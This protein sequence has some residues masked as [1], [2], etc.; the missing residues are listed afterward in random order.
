MRNRAFPFARRN[1]VV[2]LPVVDRVIVRRRSP[3]V[4]AVLTLLFMSVASSSLH[5]G[6]ASGPVVDAAN[7]HTYYLLTPDT[8]TNSEAEA[9]ALGGNL[10]TVRNQ[11]EN[12]FILTT[13]GSIAN[14]DLA[15]GLWDP[16]PNDGTGAMHAADFVW[17]SGDPSSYRHWGSGEPSDD[18]GQPTGEHYTAIIVPPHGSVVAGD[19][20]DETNVGSGTLDWGVVEILPEPTGFVLLAFAMMP[21]LRVRK[22]LGSRG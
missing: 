7:G 15:I 2:V 19:W 16:T 18:P 13:F 22:V 14:A 4:V 11:A 10:A 1:S 5:G 12:T 20:N 3:Y 9:V 8:W 17:I 21:L 6:I